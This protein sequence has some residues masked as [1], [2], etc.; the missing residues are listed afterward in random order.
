ME[1]APS[2]PHV[3]PQPD[4]SPGHGVWLGFGSG[5]RVRHVVGKEGKGGFHQP[6]SERPLRCG[7][8]SP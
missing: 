6:D 1:E 2:R 7:E 8:P 4:A 5:K 3:H